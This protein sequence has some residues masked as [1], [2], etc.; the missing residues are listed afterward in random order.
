MIQIYLYLPKSLNTV[1][2]IRGTG[3]ESLFSLLMRFRIRTRMFRLFSLIQIQIWTRI[4]V[5]IKV[6][7]IWD[8]RSTDPPLLHFEPPSLCFEASSPPLW[9]SIALH[10]SISSLHGSWTF[11]CGSD[12]SFWLWFGSGAS[13][14]DFW[15]WFD[16]GPESGFPQWYGSLVTIETHTYTATTLPQRS[17]H[18][19]PGKNGIWC[20]NVINNWG[21]IPQISQV[22]ISP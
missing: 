4:L 19:N 3:S 8:Q 21:Y 20:H 16:S 17:Q 14:N 2:R 1:L 11:R 13:G 7:Q 9:T 18:R 5:L 22:S 6:M 12:T 10:S 15:L